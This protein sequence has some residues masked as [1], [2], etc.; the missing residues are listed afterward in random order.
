MVI[1][2]GSD[3]GSALIEQTRK[4]GVVPEILAL[5]ALRERFLASA[6]P[7]QPRDGFASQM[8]RNAAS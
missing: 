5:N 3:L 8:V 1:T 7:V 2:L 6:L 4:Q